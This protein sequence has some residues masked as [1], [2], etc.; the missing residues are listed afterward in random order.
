MTIKIYQVE[1]KSHISIMKSR[2]KFVVVVL[3]VIGHCFVLLWFA[4]FT[5]RKWMTFMMIL[6]TKLG[7]QLNFSDSTW[8]CAMDD[9]VLCMI[10]K[11]Q[12]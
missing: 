1:F 9:I 7:V 3:V 6:H 2:I 10:K 12:L 5:W 8:F 4:S 11:K